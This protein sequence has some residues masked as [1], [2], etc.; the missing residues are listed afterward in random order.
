MIRSVLPAIALGLC[1][2]PTLTNAAEPDEAGPYAV[3]VDAYDLGDLAFE[4]LEFGGRSVE[5][6]AA[7]Y[8][9]QDL[10]DG[11]FPL[12][13]FMHGRH[14]TC[15]DPQ[16]PQG[17]PGDGSFLGGFI[18]WPCLSGRV[19]IPS[20]EGYAPVAELLASHGY[21]VVSVS[22]NGINAFDNEPLDFGMT[23]RADL[24]SE[25]L[26]LW[27]SWHEGV[28]GPLGRRF[29]GAIDFEHI[30]M[31]GHSRGGEGV[32]TWASLDVADGPPNFIDAAFL[33]A[34][35][36]FERVVV[37]DV[38]LA[39]ML[40]YCDG[41]VFDLSGAHY[42]DDALGTEDGDSAPKYAFTMDGS[43]H[44]YYNTVW[45]PGT[46]EAG[47]VDDFAGFEDLVGTDPHCGTASTQRLGETEQQRSL[48]AYMLAFFRL[49]LGGEEEFADVLRGAVIPASGAVANPAVTYFGPDEPAERL[50]INPL[51]SIDALS[52]NAL[53]GEVSA[54]EAETY[55]L[56]GLGTGDDIDHCVDEPGMFQG[57]LFDGRQPHTPGLGQLRLA[58]REG[59]RWTNVLPDALDVSDLLVLS[60]RVAVD[61][62]S[63]LA[64]PT[65]P[66]LYLS[67]AGGAEASVAMADWSD[68][69]V[70]PSGTLYPL[71][72][73]KVLH[74]VRVPLSAF[75]GVDLTQLSTIAL[76]VDRG[77]T[78]L[79]V[80]DLA[81]SDMAP[82]PPAGTSTG[83]ATST[84]VG[85]E[86][87]TAPGDSSTTDPTS[88][89][90]TTTS[91]DSET[92]GGADDGSGGCG[93]RAPGPSPTGWLLGLG[94]LGLLALRRR[95]A[96]AGNY[97]LTR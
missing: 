21:V 64:N 10:T 66:R 18:E 22:T 11:P 63:E 74:T 61:F 31:V 41:D 92:D 12:V 67:D 9:P 76:G 77:T 40:P 37:R 16:T 62:E 4:P 19:P 28:S 84:S 6:R 68:A 5:L 20:H 35:V 3:D 7:V 15:F 69:L 57:A 34:P 80:S 52:T 43:N 44:N 39:V 46:F 38:P 72:P 88:V 96:P 71:L 95:R 2:L 1:A 30:G 27:A 73:K 50:D 14:S 33:L 53:G 82:P 17:V 24:L 94:G 49:H 36:D 65:S 70:S 93:C 48:A 90:S 87:T 81:L 59:G 26:E 25:H 13:M 83:E 42:V 60:I 75:E 91:T 23:A 29:E 58:L 8:S 89:S 55:A 86:S 56:C 51:D 79:V 85:D 78:A 45:S 54:T 97:G 32:A 47:A